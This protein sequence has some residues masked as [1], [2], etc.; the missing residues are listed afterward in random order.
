MP[1]FAVAQHRGVVRFGMVPVPGASIRATKSDKTIK[2]VTDSDGAYSLPDVADGSWILHIEAPGFET[3]DREVTITRDAKPTEWDMKMLQLSALKTTNTPGFTP[4]P[5]SP[6]LQ[7]VSPSQPEAA[8]RLLINGSVNN[9][10]STPFGLPR[11]FGNNRR[12]IRL[13]TGNI[14]FVGNNSV[15]DARSFSLT[16]Q[17]TPRPAYNRLQTTITFGGPFQI[18]SLLKSGMFNIS[19]NRTQNRTATLQTA[20]MPTAA[21]REGVTNPQAKALLVLYP[22][23]NFDGPGR[24]NYQVPVVGVTH[25]DNVQGMLNNIV[26]SSRDRISGNASVQTTRADNPDLFGFTDTANTSGIA[27]TITWNHRFNPRIAGVIRYQFNRTVSETLP[28]FGNR[29]DVSGAAGI[30]GNDRDARNWGPPT[31]VFASGIARLSTGSFAFDRS[32]SSG[33]SYSSNWNQRRH[34][35]GFGADYRKQQFNLLSQKDARGTFTFTGAATGND[36][37]DFLSGIPTVSSI[38][39]GN[40]DK[41]FRQSFTNA[42]LT[43]DWRLNA[44]ITLMLG[45]RWEHEAPISERYGRLVNLNITPGFTSATPVVAGTAHDSLIRTDKGGFQPRLGLAWRPRSASSLVVRAGYGV[46]RDTSVY[47]AIADQMAQQAPIS[48][49]LSVQNTAATPLTLA[50]GFRSSTSVTATTFAIDPNFR[51]GN[52]QNWQLAIQHDLPAAMQMIIT[53][54]GI[55]GTHIPQRVLPNTFP[56]G[57]VNPCRSCPAGFVYMSSYGNSSRNSGTIELRRR[58]RNGFEASARYTFAKAIDDAGLGGY[59]IAQNWL[60]LRAERGLSNF[61]QRHQVVVQTQYTTG[62]LAVIGGF[63]DGWRGKAFKEWTMTTQLT[64]GSGSPLTPVILA[65]VSGTGFTGTLRPNVTGLPIYLNGALNPTAFATPVPG[66]WGNAGRNSITGPRQFG[67]NAS[68]ART[69]RVNDR[70]SMDLR[71]DAT[72][73]LNHVTFPRWNT[74]VNSAQFGLPVNANPMRSLQPSL[75]VRF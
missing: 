22:L 25:G 39:L 10:A 70:V 66:Q 12:T 73:V 51:V 16:G 9:G 26:L 18:P 13:Y 7:V 3:V 2:T 29:I 33:I 37:A 55:K 74:T 64:A 45:V 8:D 32:Q 41:Y 6:S 60:D 28:Y 14:F 19:Y 75:R 21:E 5:S 1:L 69:F 34:S 49:S 61:D 50:D 65:P 42:F 17:D 54:L 57:A 44:S 27:A 20:Q 35:L 59:Y 24:Y 15:L 72:N 71:V 68:L 52:A 43:D 4:A 56:T 67:L 63:W 30:S 40:A 23:P 38:A 46:Y 31:L 62:M 36:F 58:Q 11:A 53:Y 47:R 48:K